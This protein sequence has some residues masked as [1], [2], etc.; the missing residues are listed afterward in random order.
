MRILGLSL[1][2]IAGVALAVPKNCS[3]THISYD[4][5]NIILSSGQTTSSE[6]LFLLQNISQ[7]SLGLNH[8]KQNP[9]ASAGWASQIQAGHWSAL[10]LPAGNKSFALSCTHLKSP[11]Q[12]VSC[13]K[14]LTACEMTRVGFPKN[15]SGGY[16]AAEDLS[17]S[18]L[19]Q[20]LQQRGFQLK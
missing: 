20:H 9:G 18:K 7:Q 5:N 2:M 1:M 10:V 8:T 11:N 6:Q 13:K 15:S 17:F 16:W 19:K 14:R 3:T 12:N 4:Q